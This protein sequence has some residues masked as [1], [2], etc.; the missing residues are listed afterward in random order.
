MR[1]KL[2]TPICIDSDFK[3]ENALEKEEDTFY[4]LCYFKCFAKYTTQIAKYTT[5]ILKRRKNSNTQQ[6]A[7]YTTG[8]AKYTTKPKKIEIN[9]V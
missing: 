7:K 8:F 2:T 3:I 1:T 6:L 9:K 4:I 5:Q